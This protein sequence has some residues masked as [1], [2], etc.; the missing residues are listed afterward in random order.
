MPSLGKETYRDRSEEKRAGTAR[1][2]GGATWVKAVPATP[3]A[4]MLLPAIFLLLAALLMQG[5]G[6]G[7]PEVSSTFRQARLAANPMPT[8][9]VVPTALSERL[10]NISGGEAGI[11]VWYGTEG[12]YGI[13]ALPDGTIWVG[14]WSKTATTAGG[15]LLHYGRQGQLLATMPAP[16]GDLD[17]GGMVRDLDAYGSTLWAVVN[18]SVFGIGQDGQVT[19]INPMPDKID[20]KPVVS[21]SLLM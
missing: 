4:T 16:G 2:I 20:G 3:V 18:S 9:L 8:T 13:A 10:F 17:M 7:G 6:T 15:R 12:L 14:D 21:A 5:S 1:P 11:S 19:S